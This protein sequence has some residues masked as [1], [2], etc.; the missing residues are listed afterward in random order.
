LSLILEISDICVG[1]VFHGSELGRWAPRGSV[2][3]SISGHDQCTCRSWQA[4]P[5]LCTLIGPRICRTSW[6]RALGMRGGGMMAGTWR[7]QGEK[8][9]KVSWRKRVTKSGAT[10]RKPEQG[11]A[12]GNIQIGLSSLPPSSFLAFLE[13]HSSLALTNGDQSDCPRPVIRDHSH[14]T[15][16]CQYEC[17]CPWA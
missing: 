16:A 3:V 15:V 10:R 9:A 6:W 13:D 8:R 4:A 12:S 1:W 7:I 5:L 11:T 17:S 14:Q 2:A